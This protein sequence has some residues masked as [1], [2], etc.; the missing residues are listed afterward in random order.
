MAQLDTR[1]PSKIFRGTVDEVFSHRSEIPPG[2]T[3]ELKVFEE[4]PEVV[5]NENGQTTR[6]EP[7]DKPKQLRGRGMLAAQPPPAVFPQWVNMPVF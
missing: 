5:G 2:A 4:T 1:R 6:T 7:V 3:V